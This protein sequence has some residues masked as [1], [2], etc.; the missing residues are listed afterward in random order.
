MR[1]KLI[2]ALLLDTNEWMSQPFEALCP[3]VSCL[4]PLPVFGRTRVTHYKPFLR[5]GSL[6]C[7]LGGSEPNPACTLVHSLLR[8]LIP[9][10]DKACPVFWKRRFI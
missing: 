6:P 8:W 9:N 4:L 1:K 10:K 7:P 5:A 3:E 2:S